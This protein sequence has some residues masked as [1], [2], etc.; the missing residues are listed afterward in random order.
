[1]KR[2]ISIIIGIIIGIMG[3]LVMCS[4]QDEIE[5]VKTSSEVSML[6]G[7]SKN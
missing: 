4:H 3:L 7:R 1:M 6:V 5:K 2:G